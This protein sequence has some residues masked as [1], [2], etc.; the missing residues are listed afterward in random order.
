MCMCMLEFVGGE[1]EGKEGAVLRGHVMRLFVY[2]TCQ[3]CMLVYAVHSLCMSHVSCA[4]LCMSRV[5]CACL[6]MLYTV[7]MSCVGCACLCM[8]R[9]GCACLC[10]LY[11]VCMSH[12]GCACLCML[13]TVCRNKKSWWIP[14]EK[15][16]KDVTDFLLKTVTLNALDC[17]D[18]L[19]P[20]ST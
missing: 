2:V 15:R 7:C 16:K 4:C 8:S 14:F 12:V 13:Y 5:G 17:V 1:G 19:T 11:T 6:C 9:V 3:L 20:R 18:L 10:M